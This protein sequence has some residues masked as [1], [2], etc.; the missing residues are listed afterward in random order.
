MMPF[1]ELDILN[2]H[3]SLKLN[4]NWSVFLEGI[5]LTIKVMTE[6]M[7]LMEGANLVVGT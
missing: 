2:N 7:A 4:I 6:T 1:E 3:P 5:L